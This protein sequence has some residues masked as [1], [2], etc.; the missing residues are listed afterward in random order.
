MLAVLML[1]SALVFNTQAAG[2]PTGTEHM[3]V[4][5]SS[6]VTEAGDGDIV[7]IYVNVKN[8]FYATNMRWPVLFDLNAFEL[9]GENGNARAFGA[10]AS[11]H[12]IF[13]A[14]D[15]TGETKLYPSGY[16]PN[17]YGL[18]L[19]H[20]IGGAESGF[21]KCYNEP[22]GMVCVTFQLRVKEGSSGTGNVLIPPNSTLFYNQAMEN[23]Q[24]P[25]SIYRWNFVVGSTLILT[26]TQISLGALDPGIAPVEG[27]PTEVII[28]EFDD[29]AAD[30]LGFNG[31]VYGFPD[32][33]IYNIFVDE[34]DIRV[35]VDAVGGAEMTVTPSEGGYGTG[36]L[37][38]ITYAGVLLKSYYIV[39]LG[40][41]NGDCGIDDIDLSTA[42]AASN[43]I[44][45]WVNI[46]YDMIYGTVGSPFKKACDLDAD[47]A[48][49]AIDVSNLELFYYGYRTYSQNCSGT[50]TV[51]TT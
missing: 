50:F 22:D 1:T 51:P 4:T 40:D 43:G 36:T 17:R 9:V 25:D 31:Y 29:D 46:E 30:A 11:D 47:T 16:R 7:T 5:L 45:D 23:P 32:D 12:A 10:L 28:E 41:V 20:W 6:N 14:I 27:A 42:D 3:E 2:T 39:I 37:L 15:K 24:N 19:L 44:M 33:V 8:N 18:L 38:E 34:D 26:P 49:D 48:A 13:S 35:Y 21:T